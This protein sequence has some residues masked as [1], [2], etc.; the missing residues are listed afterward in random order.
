MTGTPSGVAA[1]MNLTAWLKDGD[2]VE[3]EVEGMDRISYEM[4]FED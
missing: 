4:V 3:I 2:I 1:A